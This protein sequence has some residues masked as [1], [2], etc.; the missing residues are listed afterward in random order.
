[1]REGEE[2][3]RAMS[4][5]FRLISSECS[6]GNGN[7]GIWEYG[8]E[9]RERFAMNRRCGTESGVAIEFVRST[10][11]VADVPEPGSLGL[12]AWAA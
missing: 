1:M 11:Q 5:G 6:L 9:N 3:Q 12:K 4:E 8:E 10:K 7:M 2:T